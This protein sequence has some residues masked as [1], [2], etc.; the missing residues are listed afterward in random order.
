MNYKKNLVSIIGT[1]FNNNPLD[2]IKTIES[3]LSQN[4]RLIEFIVVLPPFR[5]N[6]QIFRIYKKK[7]KI[8]ITKKFLNLPESLN[9]ALKNAKGE[10][11][12]RIDFD[13][14]YLTNKIIK[15]VNYMNKNKHISILG[16]GY[17]EKKN[18]KKKYYPSTSLII[19]VYMFFF[20]PI[21]HPS[22]M[23]RSSII[24]EGFKY[25]TKF[26]ACE[27][28]EFWFKAAIKNKNI[29]NLR[30]ILLKY[31]KG[32]ILRNITNFKYN[33]VVRKC[34][35]IKL[36]GF[37]FGSLNILFFFVFKVFFHRLIKKLLLI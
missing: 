17:I 26:N 2:I 16:C 20:N 35:S 31:K 22:V 23:I 7:I 30:E 19:K 14:E 24:R 21:C 32:K 1:S 4:Y 27:D 9:V 37:F 18:R 25:N 8:I 6:L 3:V 5:N 29:S 36:F 10:Y 28:L 34:Y 13:D 33:Y 15:Q 12:A 11:I